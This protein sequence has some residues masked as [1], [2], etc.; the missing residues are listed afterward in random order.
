MAGS[1]W[2]P[3]RLDGFILTERLGSGTYATVY[4]AYAKVGAGRGRNRGTRT[5]RAWPRARQTLSAP[6]RVP[7]RESRGGWRLH[8]TS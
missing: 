4:K 8:E 1:G 3:P 2:A 6:R 7:G 5:L